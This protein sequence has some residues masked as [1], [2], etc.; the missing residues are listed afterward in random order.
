MGYVKNIKLFFDGVSDDY[1]PGKIYI[2]DKRYTT[3]TQQGFINSRGISDGYNKSYFIS[4][5][6]EE[7][8]IQE[9]IIKPIIN[10]DLSYLIPILK[11][12]NII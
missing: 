1:L 5:T 2:T 7:Y 4:A 3:E 8:N 12:H 9:G 6:E 10:E 11:N